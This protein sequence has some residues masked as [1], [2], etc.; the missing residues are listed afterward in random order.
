MRRHRGKGAESLSC[1][2][3][4][5]PDEQKQKQQQAEEGRKRRRGMRM[6][7][8]RRIEPKKMRG[9]IWH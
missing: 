9:T 4:D 3:C 7:R 2:L 5:S 6:K 1:G 8:K